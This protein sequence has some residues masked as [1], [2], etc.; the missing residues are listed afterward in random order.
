MAKRRAFTPEFRR[1]AVEL[2]YRSDTTVRQVARDL[3]IGEGLLGKLKAEGNSASQA[4]GTPVTKSCPAQARVS[5]GEARTTIASAF[6]A[7]SRADH[8]LASVWPRD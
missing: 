4:R 2:S 6:S 8:Q 3:G 1:E 7:V 5:A